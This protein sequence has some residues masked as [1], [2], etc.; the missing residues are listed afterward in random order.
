MIHLIAGGKSHSQ[1]RRVHASPEEQPAME[2]WLDL[3]RQRAASV[4]L[5]GSAGAW[6]LERLPGAVL[7]DSLEDAL[8]RAP[9]PVLVSPG[10]PMEQPDRVKVATWS[11]S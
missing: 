2:Q 8:R 3:V 10:F 9:R 7:C 4:H 1:G 6:L 11:S 5:F